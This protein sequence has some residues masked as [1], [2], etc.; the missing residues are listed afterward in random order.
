MNF[1]PLLDHRFDKETSGMSGG[2][3][4]AHKDHHRKVYL[5]LEKFFKQITH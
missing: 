5:K 1:Q 2:A 3:Y 4:V